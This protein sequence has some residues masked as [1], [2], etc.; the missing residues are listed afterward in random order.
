[1]VATH[2]NTWGNLLSMKQRQTERRQLLA[3]APSPTLRKEKQNSRDMKEMRRSDTSG[4]PS[5]STS[6]SHLEKMCWGLP[7]EKQKRTILLL[8]VQIVEE[9]TQPLFRGCVQALNS[10]KQSLDNLT[11]QHLGNNKTSAAT[12]P[13]ITSL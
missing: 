4:V 9:P 8:N 1:M 6:P 10:K 3:E 13:A 5:G 12:R 2:G 11:Q 7:D